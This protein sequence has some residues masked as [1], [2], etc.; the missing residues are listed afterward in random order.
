MQNFR[1][2]R[3]LVGMPSEKHRMLYEYLWLSPSYHLAYATRVQKRKIKSEDLPKDF[4]KVLATYDQLGDVYNLGFDDW[5]D[6]YGVHALVANT[7]K[8]KLIFQINLSKP[9]AQILQD[10]ENFVEKINFEPFKKNNRKISFEKNRIR[11]STLIDRH[12]LVITRSTYL[13]NKTTRDEA[14]IP[15]WKMALGQDSKSHILPM[16][17]NS[18]LSKAVKQIKTDEQSKKRRSNKVKKAYMTMV[19]SK[20]L[21]E[22]LYIAENAARGKFPSKQPVPHCLNF[23]YERLADLELQM[24]LLDE[25]MHKKKLYEGSDVYVKDLLRNRNIY[26][27]SKDKRARRLKRQFKKELQVSRNDFAS[28]FKGS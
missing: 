22:S 20:N 3:E 28:V 25:A 24:Y 15:Y 10:F 4:S 12:N 17:L 11:I 13:N 2:N 7:N 16:M 26:Q 1:K 14:K 19:I 5:W 6:K 21:K 18:S 8:A 27:E 9:K 23:D